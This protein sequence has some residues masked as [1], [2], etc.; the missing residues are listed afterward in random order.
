MPESYRET[1]KFT[2]ETVLVDHLGDHGIDAV[3]LTHYDH[4]DAADFD[5]VHVHHLSWGA[6]RAATSTARTPMV[7]TMHQSSAPRARAARFVMSRSDAVVALWPEEAVALA[8]NY[9][10]DGART[11]VIPN[12]IDPQVFSF[13]ERTAPAAGEPWRLLF[14]GQLIAMKGVDNLLDAVAAL[15]DVLPLDLTLSYHSAADEAALRV[16]AERLGISPLVHFA[17]AAP[18]PELSERYRSAHI[19]VLPSRTMEALPSAMTEAMLSGCFPVATDVGGI[20][21]QLGRFG[22]VLDR[23]TPDVIAA[24]IRRAIETYG[25]HQARAAEMRRVAVERFSV[26][27]MVRA[28]ASLYRELVA[29]DRRPRRHRGRSRAG[30]ALMNVPLAITTRNRRRPEHADTGHDAESKGVALPG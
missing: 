25:D 7:F 22:I 12:G 20:R 11:E 5:V 13:A 15:K 26:A 28:H 27:A 3:P 23:S 10:L 8:A 17:G 24:G 1:V 18:Q 21:Q 14:V 29:A 16:Q 30:T 19:A 4:F 2:P 6:M 9:H